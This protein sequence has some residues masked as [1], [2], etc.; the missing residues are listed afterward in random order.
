MFTNFARARARQCDA[1]QGLVVWKC[2]ETDTCQVDESGFAVCVPVGP[3][4]Q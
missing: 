3:T 2:R 4:A 1:T